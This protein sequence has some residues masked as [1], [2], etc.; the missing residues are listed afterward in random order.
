MKCPIAPIAIDGAPDIDVG[1]YVDLLWSFYSIY[2]SAMK[3]LF[4]IS[5]GYIIYLMRF[6][7]D[8]DAE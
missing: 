3:I 2:N 7:L 1:R 8:L 4:I 6:A 5:T